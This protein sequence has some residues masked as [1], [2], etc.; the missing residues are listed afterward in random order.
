MSKVHFIN[1]Q[2]KLKSVLAEQDLDGMLVTNLTNI[3][4]LSGFTGSAATLL[5]LP[6]K[7]YFISDGRYMEQSRQQIKGFERIINNDPHLKTIQNEKL[8]PDGLNLAFEADF[9]N[10]T[11]FGDMDEFFPEVD[12]EPTSRMVE[13]IAAIKDESEIELIR[14]AVKIT[15]Q[16]FSEIIPLLKIG[17]TERQ[18]ANVIRNKYYEY[19]DGEGFETIVAGGPNSALPHARPSDRQFKSGDFVVIDMGALFAGYCADMTRTI[20]I[21]EATD[22]HR[23]IYAIVKEAQQAGCAAIKAG[24]HCKIPD[25]ATRNVITEKGYG[26]YFN[27]GTGHGIGLEVHTMPRLSQISED[28]LL[29]NYVVTVEP[30]IYLPDWNGVRIEDDVIVKQDGCE[31]LNQSTKELLIL[32]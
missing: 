14:E 30:G 17:A 3:R 19:G 4:Y 26:D 32:K 10:V 13:E 18:I 12:W 20:L 28:T 25:E 5:I 1:R 23:E 7:Q 16:T 6:E 21:G 9:V 24:V 27:H 22:K 29:E 2:S 15:D 8:I 31:I 11:Q